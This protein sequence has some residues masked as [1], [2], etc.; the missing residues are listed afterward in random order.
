M[1]KLFTNRVAMLQFHNRPYHKHR[2]S[3]ESE[4]DDNAI[5]AA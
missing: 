5:D 4:A 3:V 2:T 1:D